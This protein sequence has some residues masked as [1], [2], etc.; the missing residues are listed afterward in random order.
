MG[1]AQADYQTA[2]TAVRT[3]TVVGADD[4]AFPQ[5]Y[6]AALS[7]E[8]GMRACKKF[9][10]KWTPE[11][12]KA[13]QVAV[14]EGINLNPQNTHLSFQPNREDGSASLPMTPPSAP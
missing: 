11:L 4:I 1:P 6:F 10:K 2:E 14:V 3:E 13:Y 12:E 8:L 7:A 9:G 5:E